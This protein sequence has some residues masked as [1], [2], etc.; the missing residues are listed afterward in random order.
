[1]NTYAHVHMYRYKHGCVVRVGIRRLI[2][3]GVWPDAT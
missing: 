2:V 1:M 3:R